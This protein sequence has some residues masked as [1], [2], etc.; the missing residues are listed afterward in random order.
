MIGWFVNRCRYRDTDDAT[1]HSEVSCVTQPQ[2]RTCKRTEKI[3]Q[4]RT[5]VSTWSTVMNQYESAK[6]GSDCLQF[7]HFFSTRNFVLTLFLSLV[8]F[9]F[10]SS[11][12]LS[13]FWFVVCFLFL[14]LKYND[15]LRASSKI[16]QK[17]TTK[18]FCLKK[19]RLLYIELHSTD[20]AYSTIEE[21][22]CWVKQ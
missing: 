18:M 21:K 11:S 9:L 4:N 19:Y 2:H 5:C 1:R 3:K 14:L 20:I 16:R 10:L 8:L 17:L 7:C 12:F 6:L 13:L 15:F 22:D